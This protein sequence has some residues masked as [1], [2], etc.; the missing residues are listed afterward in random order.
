MIHPEPEQS[1]GA[2]LN[3]G[4]SGNRFNRP[5]AGS[6]LLFRWHASDSTRPMGSWQQFRSNDSLECFP[7]SED[8]IVGASGWRGPV[9]F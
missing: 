5:T 3:D 1:N 6:W 9:S 4:P 2:R 7:F 8:K